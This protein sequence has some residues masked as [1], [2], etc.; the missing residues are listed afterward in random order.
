[1]WDDNTSTNNVQRCSP[2]RGT[3]IARTGG[4]M[5]VA[6]LKIMRDKFSKSRLTEP[7]SSAAVAALLPEEDEGARRVGRSLHGWPR[8][9]Q[10]NSRRPCP[11][12]TTTAAPGRPPRAGVQEREPRGGRSGDDWTVPLLTAVRTQ[13]Q[14]KQGRRLLPSETESF[15][16]CL[17]LRHGRDEAWHPYM[18]G[19][20]QRLCSA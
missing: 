13:Q 17:Q 7:R 8:G 18:H 1:V 5:V 4:M 16:V 15:V 14:R 19:Y 6:P 12:P 3:I 2:Q 9:Q 10:D 20:L 11:P